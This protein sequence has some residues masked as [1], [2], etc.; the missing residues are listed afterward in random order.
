MKKQLL[1]YTVIISLLLVCN[2]FAEEEAAQEK[3]TNFTVSINSAYLGDAELD[4]S[5]GSFSTVNSAVEVTAYNFS[6][7]Y[8]NETYSW[9]NRSDIDFV[10]GSNTP[11]NSLQKLGVGY[12]NRYAFDEKN[13]LV[14]FAQASSQFEDAIT[15]DSI[16]LAGLVGYNYAFTPNFV[17]TIGV[18]AGYNP[19]DW[20]VLPVLGFQYSYDEWVVKLA[21]PVS[22]VAYRFSDSFALRVDIGLESGVYQLSSSSDVARNGYVKKREAKVSLFADWN[23]MENITFSFGPQYVF[24]RRMKFYTSAH[25]RT[26]SA[27][28]IGDTWGI[29]ANV[30]IEF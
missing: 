27:E 5:S 12:G 13:F 21:F 3:E 24:A 18:V 9:N 6:V 8:E 30:N 22:N 10:K 4:D 19:L 11:W 25:N 1:I 15:G 2:A 17:V 23:C 16:T 14:Y 29:A 20:N 28:D 26:G 7:I